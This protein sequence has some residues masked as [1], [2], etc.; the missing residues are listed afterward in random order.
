MLIRRQEWP[1]KTDT[2]FTI[3]TFVGDKASQFTSWLTR[4]RNKEG[5]TDEEGGKKPNETAIEI[6]DEN[7]FFSDYFDICG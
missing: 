4:G 5:R 6:A 3:L 2:S 7:R 1:M